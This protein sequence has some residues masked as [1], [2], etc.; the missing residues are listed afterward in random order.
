MTLVGEIKLESLIAGQHS[1]SRGN[2]NDHMNDKQAFTRLWHLSPRDC[3]K[4]SSVWQA[5]H[6]SGTSMFIVQPDTGGAK[7]C[8]SFSEGCS[9]SLMKTIKTSK[10]L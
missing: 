3:D 10:N 6:N 5:I 2:R 7:A 9:N 1:P 4:H 8:Q